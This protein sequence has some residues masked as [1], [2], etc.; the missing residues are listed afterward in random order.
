MI[1]WMTRMTTMYLGSPANLPPGALH[2]AI[3]PESNAPVLDQLTDQ[4][5][6]LFQIYFLSL[7]IFFGRS[8]T[9]PYLRPRQTPHSH[10]IFTKDVHISLSRPPHASNTP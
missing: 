6:L 4:L 8:A 5:Q 2:C 7:H 10:R 9:L 3:S 1:L